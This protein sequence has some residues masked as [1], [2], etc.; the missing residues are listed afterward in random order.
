MCSWQFRITKAEEGSISGLKYAQKNVKSTPLS[1]CA[2]IGGY[3]C[4][5]ISG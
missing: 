4:K 2:N 3:L 5:N 1:M